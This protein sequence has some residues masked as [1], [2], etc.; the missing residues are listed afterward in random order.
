MLKISNLKAKVENKLVLK[1]INLNL[2]KGST[3]ALMG[4]NGSG[5]SSLAKTLIGHSDYPITSG[6]IEL[7]GSD[8]T[9]A[10]ISSRAKQGLFLSWQTPRVIAGINYRQY[11]QIIYRQRILNE[12]SLTIEQA[13]KDSE[14]RKLIMPSACRKA[15]KAAADAVELP[16]SFLE[17]GLNHG[18]S[19]GEAKKSEI[20]QM[21]LL[22]PKVAILDE[23]DSGLDITALK[24]ITTAIKKLQEETG[25]T[26]LIITHYPK[27]LEYLPPQQVHLLLDGKISKSGNMSLVDE[28]EAKG[29]AK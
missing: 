4:P 3:H 5:K 27:I 12:H 21:Y 6:K 10:S 17:R 25:L 11:L 24:I 2:A 13:R 23:L 1:G 8:I 26:L 16:H 20:L 14:V 18:F 7:A 22:K 15:V 19:G 29:Y 9:K 28:I